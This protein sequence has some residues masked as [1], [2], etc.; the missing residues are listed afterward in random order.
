[1]F[2]TWLIPEA[3]AQNLAT[4][5]VGRFFDGFA[6]SAFLAVAAGSVVDLFD[7]S[8]ID[9]PMMIFSASPFLGPVG[10]P[11]IGG[12]INQFTS[13][14]AVTPPKMHCLVTKKRDHAGAGPSTP[15][16]LCAANRYAY[17]LWK[18]C[19]LPAIYLG[20]ALIL[21]DIRKP[22]RSSWSLSS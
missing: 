21:I 15:S 5:I 4:V 8:E 16:L 2:V 9:F 1:M 22:F 10:G 20:N 7:P 14:Y 6:G 3:L 19:L 11:V 12:F 17:T 13:W 18:H